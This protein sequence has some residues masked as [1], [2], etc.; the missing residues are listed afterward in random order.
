VFLSLETPSYRRVFS[1]SGP[2]ILA[3]VQCIGASVYIY[4][5]IGVLDLLLA[6]ADHLLAR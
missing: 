1:V 3:D 6:V 2:V 5:Y 4:I